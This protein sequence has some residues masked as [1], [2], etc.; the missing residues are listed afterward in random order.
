MKNYTAKAY[1]RIGSYKK[2]KDV[3]SLTT[4]GRIW[5]EGNKQTLDSDFIIINK[6]KFGI[7]QRHNVMSCANKHINVNSYA[8]SEDEAIKLFLELAKMDSS[9]WVNQWFWDSKKENLF[10]FQCASFLRNDTLRAT[11]IELCEAFRNGKIKLI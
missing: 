5:L 8:T 3:F 9:V 4:K 1:I 6:N 10:K 11:P 2:R 7:M